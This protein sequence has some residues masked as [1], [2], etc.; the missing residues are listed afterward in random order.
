MGRSKLIADFQ[1][2]IADLVVGIREKI[3]WQSAIGIWQ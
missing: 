1:L 3:N 2:P